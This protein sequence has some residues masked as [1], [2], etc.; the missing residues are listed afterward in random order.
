M[1]LSTENVRLQGSRKLVPYPAG[2]VQAALA[3][4]HII[5]WRHPKLMTSAHHA[6]DTPK[7]YEVGLSGAGS[8]G[9][10]RVHSWSWLGQL[11]D[12]PC[13]MLCGPLCLAGRLCDGWSLPVCL[14]SIGVLHAIGRRTLHGRHQWPEVAGRA[15]L[16]GKM[17]AG[18][19]LPRT[20]PNSQTKHDCPVQDAH[21]E[22]AA[23]HGEALLSWQAPAWLQQ[24]GRQQQPASTA[25]IPSG[26]VVKAER[27]LG[28]GSSSATSSAS[29]SS[30]A[31]VGCYSSGEDG[32]V[33]GRP[34]LPATLGQ[35]GSAIESMEVIGLPN[36]GD[37]LVT[38]GVQ[39][40][41]A[42]T[43][44][45]LPGVDKTSPCTATLPQG[46]GPP[47]GSD[48]TA[49]SSDTSDT[50]SG[51]DSSGSGGPPSPEQ[52]HRGA[53]RERNFVQL[54]AL[55]GSRPGRSGAQAALRLLGAGAGSGQ[56]TTSGAGSRAARRASPAQRS[57]PT[58][59]AAGHGR[60][61]GAGCPNPTGSAGSPAAGL[62]GLR[63]PSAL[64]AAVG[65]NG[66]AACGCGTAANGAAGRA[67]EWQLLPGSPA[68]PV[69]GRSGSHVAAGER[70]AHLL[71][72]ESMSATN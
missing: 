15:S 58:A 5:R 49:D 23:L 68:N 36:V 38:A 8:D 39:A 54:D 7:V 25:S 48:S 14:H 60:A 27:H 55:F 19:R 4:R 70:Q 12:S 46:T 6:V 69:Y 61:A 52:G 34:P 16:V 9:F 40:A 17:A 26:C 45:G 11:S 51:S 28:A 41:P 22:V 21:L 35:A 33:N 53:Q 56:K 62:T 59:A 37:R 72:H 1:L 20:K 13:C 64:A 2:T 66:Q 29:G 47:A 3:L 43:A 10:L 63:P 57:G 31:C 65:G 18:C 30:T 44:D 67:V 50:D 24:P 42:A 71:L 32:G